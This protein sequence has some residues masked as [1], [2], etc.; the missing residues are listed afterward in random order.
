MT[1]GTV[2]IDPERCKGCQLCATACPQHLLGM[3]RDTLN[4]KGFHPAQLNDPLGR[5]T[6]CALCAVICPDVAITVVRYTPSA[7]TP[8]GA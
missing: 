1:H 6:G 2:R 3:N 7:R 5:C 8:V 4:L